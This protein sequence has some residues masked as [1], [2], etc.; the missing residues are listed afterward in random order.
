MKTSTEYLNLLDDIQELLQC[1][2][3]LFLQFCLSVLLYKCCLAKMIK[4]Q[5]VECLHSNPALPL[6]GYVTM[7][8]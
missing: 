6:T 8:Q 7:S 1:D 2:L 5:E 4:I 3:K